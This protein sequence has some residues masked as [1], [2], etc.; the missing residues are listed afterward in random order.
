MKIMSKLKNYEVIFEENT[1]FI[2][3][4]LNLDNSLF[5]IDKNVY[6]LY[7]DKLN[8]KNINSGRL[9]V[10][11]AREENK[12]IETA[13][14]ICEL[15][16]KLNAKRN[17]TLISIGGGITQD[18]TGFVANI[19]YRGIHWIYVPTTLLASCDS[20]I[21]GKTSLNYKKFKNLLGTFYPPDE[22]HI[23]SDFFD[24]LSDKDFKSGLGEVV[25]FNIMMGKKGLKNMEADLSKLIAK[26]K[27]IIDK[28]IKT[29]LEY[30]KTYIEQDEFDRGERIK[31]NFAHT[32]GHAV[33][34]V[35]K[36]EIPHGTAV[37]I[38]MIMADKI[39]YE[40]GLIS[41]DIKK[42]SENVL[43][44]I[45]DIDAN[46]L[47]C[48]FDDYFI[49][50]RKDKKQ[51]DDGLTAVLITKYESQAELSIVHDMTKQE[52][53]KTIIYFIKNYRSIK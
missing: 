2:S 50:V 37:A 31:L 28:Y 51:I 19:T 40:R 22:I 6:E 39:S 20:C 46:L 8:F 53:E 26:D 42:R 33:E 9:F 12:V 41:D 16:T 29:S 10:L 34:V 49:A 25:K 15:I 7:K 32:F 30:K 44:N 35:S 5:V 4:L 3:E 48:P 21:G 18:V 38:G 43:L 27:K 1:K 17:A 24:T 14:D 47:D 11:E 36:Y 23:C 52:L 13:L 45:I